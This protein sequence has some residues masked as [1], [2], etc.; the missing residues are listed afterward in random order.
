MTKWILLLQGINVS[1]QKRLP[2]PELQSLL[3]DISLQ[4]VRTYIQ[5][6]NAVFTSLESDRAVLGELI[7]NAIAEKFGFTTP[8]FLRT[9]AEMARVAEENPFLTVRSEDPACLHVTF[10]S[11][12]LTPES[13]ANLIAPAGI[14]DE[15]QCGLE[16]IYLFCPQGYGRTKLNNAFFERKLKIPVTTRNWNSVATLLRMAEELR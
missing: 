7:G 16:E 9:I 2:M 10:L 3:A 15:M 11:T 13:R 12:P 8:V 6:G 5:S 14:P 1:G 4:S